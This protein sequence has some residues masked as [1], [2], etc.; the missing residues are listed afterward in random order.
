MRSLLIILSTFLI[1]SLVLA[2]TNEPVK[3][4]KKA[5]K[6]DEQQVFIF[7]DSITFYKKELNE[8]VEEKTK[9][10]TRSLKKIAVSNGTEQK[11]R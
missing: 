1:P 7:P 6:A 8:L 5:K 2:Q 10:L 9:A 3:S 11:R 4:N